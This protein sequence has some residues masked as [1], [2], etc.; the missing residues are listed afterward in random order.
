ML[1]SCS[2]EFYSLQSYHSTLQQIFST[3]RVR[4]HLD[5]NSCFETEQ[6]TLAGFCGMQKK[7]YVQ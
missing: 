5:M 4:K 7:S 6:K 2:P 1:D 3:T